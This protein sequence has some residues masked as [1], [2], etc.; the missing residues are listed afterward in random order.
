M[1]G[2]ERLSLR[3]AE[4]LKDR[5]THQLMPSVGLEAGLAI[6]AE[7]EGLS[8]RDRALAALEGKTLRELGEVARRLGAHWS[9]YSLEEAGL[10]FLKRGS[11]RSAKLHGVT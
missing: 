9:D 4:A 11:R 7:A 3:V 8:K 10:Q 1:S 5:C 2:V 6:P